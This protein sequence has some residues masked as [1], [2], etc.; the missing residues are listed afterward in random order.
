MVNIIIGEKGTGKTGKLVD[1]G[2]RMIQTDRPEYLIEY[3][4]SRNMHD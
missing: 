1:M 3:L 2:T 4:R